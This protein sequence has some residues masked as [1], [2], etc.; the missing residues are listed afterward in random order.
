MLAII[1]V[2]TVIVACIVSVGIASYRDKHMPTLYYVG[3]RREYD[4]NTDATILIAVIIVAIIGF[5]LSL[6][7]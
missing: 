2:S 7:V 4:L 1:W 3:D 5:I 6:M